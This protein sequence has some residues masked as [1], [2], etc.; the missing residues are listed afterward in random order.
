[1]SSMSSLPD[2][3]IIIERSMVRQF[4]VLSQEL[5]I[6]SQQRAIPMPKYRI[7]QSRWERVNFW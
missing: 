2:M 5:P 7:A 4:Q 6:D 3:T 1:M